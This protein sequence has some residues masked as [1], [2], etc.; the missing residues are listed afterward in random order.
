VDETLKLGAIDPV[1]FIATLARIGTPSFALNLRSVPKVGAV[2]DW[3]GKT[4][5][6]AGYDGFIM[7]DR[8]SPA[9]L[10]Q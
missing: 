7:V 9:Q 3:L 10:M 1:S 4:Q 2:A 8:I 6:A 5:G